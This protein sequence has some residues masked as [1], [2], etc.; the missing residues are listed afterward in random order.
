MQLDPTLFSY[1]ERPK[2][3][4][5]NHL[6]F[7]HCQSLYMGGIVA[8]IVG[9]FLCPSVFFANC[10]ANPIPLQNP[11]KSVRCALS[12]QVTALLSLLSQIL[13]PN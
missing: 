9:M 3:H 8:L 13:L 1:T 11:V 10:C 12:L 5:P 7:S 2:S 6:F 4:F